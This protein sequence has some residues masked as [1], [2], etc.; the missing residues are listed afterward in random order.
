M[1]YDYDAIVLEQ[2]SKW[3]RGNTNYRSAS[4]RMRSWAMRHPLPQFVNVIVAEYK[5]LMAER[6]K[7]LAGTMALLHVPIHLDWVKS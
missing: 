3:P 6:G 4:G 1:G 2:A 5:A 7:S